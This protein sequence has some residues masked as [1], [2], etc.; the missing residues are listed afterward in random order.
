MGLANA[1]IDKLTK[2]LVRDLRTLERVA[3]ADMIQHAPPSHT[4]QSL[5]QPQNSNYEV[6]RSN[7]ALI[8]EEFETWA[9]LDALN[10][11]DRTHFSERAA[12]IDNFNP[13][14]LQVHSTVQ[15][16]LSLTVHTIANWLESIYAAG[17]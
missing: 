10:A 14:T 11:A 17:E 13:R 15:E 12:A 5:F 9:L 3:H 8:R 1:D 2:N 7:H 16:P 4:G 6:R